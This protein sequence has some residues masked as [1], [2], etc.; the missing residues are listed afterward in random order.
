MMDENITELLR[1]VKENPDLPILPL[2]DGDIVVGGEYGWWLGAF[3]RCY[4]DE[5]IIDE[6]YGD[7]CVRLKS[8]GGEDAII[9][10]MAEIKYD[11]TEADYDRAE[12]ELKTMWQRAIFINIVP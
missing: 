7:G 8:D 3:G 9:E 12:A 6:W 2:V 11:G 1:L 10:G 4:I 5:Y